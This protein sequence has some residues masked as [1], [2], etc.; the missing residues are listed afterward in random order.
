MG[1]SPSPRVAIIGSGF[2]G[3]AA[4]IALRK[5]GIED[6]VIFE[7]APALG[8]TWWHN[9]YPGAEVDLE[10][11][12]YSFSFERYDWT[13]THA[14]WAELQ[15]YLNH[16]ADK[17]D[18]RR[19]M[20]FD[21][22]V[23]DVHWSDTEHT[24]TVR[25]ASGDD[26]GQFTAVIS[27]VGFLNIPL[28]PPFARE[29][30]DFEGA[31]C[32]TSRW[33]DGLD[34]TGK[35]IGVV[36]T[37]SSAVQVVTEAERVG[38]EVKIFQI[39]P[40]WILPKDSRDFTPLERRLNR[41]AP[42]YA[43][44]RLKLYLGYDLRQVRSSHA[45]PDGRTNQRKHKA[46]LAFLHRE[47]GDRPDL[48]E[49]A[50]PSF[51]YEG[52]RTVV[53]DTYYRALRSPKVSLIPHAVK[54][55]S[56]TGAIDANGDEH[57]LDIIVLATGF[58]AANYLGNYDVHGQGGVELHDVWQG[59]PE[60]FLGMMVPKFPN[61]FIM[62]GPNTNSIPLVSFY[63][64]QA[65]FTASLIARAAKTRASNIEVR[66]SAFVIYNDWVQ[67]A[68]AKTV[69]AQVQNYFQ[70]G[71]GRIVSQWPFGA[72]PYILATKLLR[73]IAVRLS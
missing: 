58:D 27:A 51:P 5:R 28:I 72:T 18:L 65:A 64:A 35:K 37:G 33:I 57:E 30:N 68:L 23:T 50:T 73:R 40:N 26:H 66:R 54:G 44:R 56:R 42:V 12:I 41:L 46:A 70:A 6:F 25:T 3:I 53:S 36:G 47:L 8:G 34:M 69:W 32:H 59:E 29:Q 17:W 63:E 49:L 22:K 4:A 71:T 2:S 7:Q 45:R 1:G 20:K 67:A 9:R 55:L 15:G 10:S 39:E 43:Y 52:R 21:E 48:L 38:K 11:H 62:Y 60:A 19:R 13:R 61:F 24:Y 31:I 14:G 16:V